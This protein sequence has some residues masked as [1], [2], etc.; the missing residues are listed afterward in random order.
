MIKN[1][2][3]NYNSLKNLLR[4]ILSEK[5]FK[6]SVNVS[7]VAEDL[8]KHYQIDSYKA[9]IAGLL[10][11]ICKEFSDEQNI[12]LISEKEC[13]VSFSQKILHG[14]AA[15]IYIQKEY[16]ITDEDLLNAVKYH[17]TGRKD[18]SLL[19]KIVFTADYISPERK[20]KDLSLIRTLA[21]KDLDVAVLKKLST[22]ILGCV[23]NHR[24][25]SENTL[26]AYNQLT[27]QMQKMKK[28]R[29]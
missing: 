13:G 3:Y 26:L 18:M 7:L 15:S 22:A 9:K 4:G 16:G 14:P 5:R 23:M 20:W 24:C 29:E 6:H 2:N 17:T 19:E 11:D 21:Y 8:A 27:E 25:I 1:Q 10:H 12:K 28:E